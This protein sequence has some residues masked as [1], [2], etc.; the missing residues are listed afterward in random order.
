MDRLTVAVLLFVTS[1]FVAGNTYGDDREFTAILQGAQEVPPVVTETSGEIE[2]EF[3]SD[4]TEAEFELEVNDGVAI[5]AAH[6]HCAPEGAN[7]PVVAFLFGMIPGGFDVDDEIAEF[8]LTDANI[9]AVGADCVP[10]TGMAI[11]DLFDLAEAMR[12]GYIYTN[13]HS[14]ANPPGEVR[15]QLAEEED[16][17]EEDD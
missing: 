9:S 11:G 6:L 5:T 16:D 7:G 15:G 4:Y 17:D 13:V 14:V 8:T 10:T 12:N 1:L 2:V 3:N